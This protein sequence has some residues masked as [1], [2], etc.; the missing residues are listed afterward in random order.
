MTDVLI[1]FSH[2]FLN[3]CIN[4][5]SLTHGVQCS[6]DR[7]RIDYKLDEVLKLNE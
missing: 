2:C 3:C 1:N 4:P 6:K 7:L 5:N